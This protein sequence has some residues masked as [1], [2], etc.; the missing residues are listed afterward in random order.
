MRR[1]EFIRVLAG[2]VVAWPHGARAQ[3]KALPVIGFSTAGEPMKSR[4][5]LRLSGKV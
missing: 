1:R 3:Q 2:T 4:S 5:S